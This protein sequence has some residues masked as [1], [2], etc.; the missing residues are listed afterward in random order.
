LI[1]LW[2]KKQEAFGV[3][4]MIIVVT[5]TNILVFVAFSPGEYARYRMPTE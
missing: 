4:F 3:F 2:R 5:L 1:L